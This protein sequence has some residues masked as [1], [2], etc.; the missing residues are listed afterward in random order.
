LGGSSHTQL[1]ATALWRIATP[2]EA[3]AIHLISHSRPSFFPQRMAAKSPNS[4]MLRHAHFGSK[5]GMQTF[6]AKC[7]NDRFTDW[8]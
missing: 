4:P 8:L 2:V 3:E 1:L 5:G 7:M 6:A